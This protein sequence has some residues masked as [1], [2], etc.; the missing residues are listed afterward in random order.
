MKSSLGYCFHTFNKNF[1]N[2]FIVNIWFNS[3]G[4]TRN[5]IFIKKKYFQ[6]T[7]SFSKVIYF[8]I[9]LE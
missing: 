9:S 8:S 6:K 1:F 4:I 7:K 5:K 2:S 3:S